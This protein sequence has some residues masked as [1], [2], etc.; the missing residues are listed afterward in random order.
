M[1][2]YVDLVQL[3]CV[4]I[5]TFFIFA[6]PHNPIVTPT[7]DCCLLVLFLV[8]RVSRPHHCAYVCLGV[9]ELPSLEFGY[10]RLHHD[11][12][13]LPPHLRFVLDQVRY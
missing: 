12:H 5:F 2:V 9:G 13:L 1:Q 11:C 4:R 8:W 6:L 10:R 3:L 7:Q